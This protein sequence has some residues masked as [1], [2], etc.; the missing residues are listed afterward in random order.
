M[1]EQEHKCEEAT[2]CTCYMLADEPNPDCPQHMG[3]AW[4][5]RCGD[6]GKFM[7]WPKEYTN[8]K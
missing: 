6:C 2:H 7:P 1:P 8:G 5:P 3:P 4:P